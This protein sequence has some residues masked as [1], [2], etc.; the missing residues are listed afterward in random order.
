MGFDSSSSGANTD[1]LLS[2]QVTDGNYKE[3]M[4]TSNTVHWDADDAAG[5]GNVKS[6]LRLLQN[7]DTLSAAEGA[8]AWDAY[9]GFEYG[10]NKYWMSMSDKSTSGDELFY[11]SGSGG[12][13]ASSAL[14]W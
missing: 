12:Y 10:S 11:V 5:E 1:M 13:G 3:Q 4:Y 14:H 7:R 2:A 6:V 8:L 9:G